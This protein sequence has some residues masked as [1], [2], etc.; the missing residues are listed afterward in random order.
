ML[1]DLKKQS[2]VLCRIFENT[3]DLKREQDYQRSSCRR[4]IFFED[5][6]SSDDGT[7]WHLTSLD[8]NIFDESVENQ[9]MAAIEAI[10]H[11]KNEREQYPGWYIA[12][13]EV[14]R[15][16]Q[17]KTM[18]YSC[19]I[20]IDFLQLDEQLDLCYEFVWRCE[21]GMLAYHG[22]LQKGIYEI[23]RAYLN[24]LKNEGEGVIEREGERV[25]NWFYIGLVLLREYREEGRESEW[26]DILQELTRY[27]DVDSFAKAG[28]E[29]EKIK[30][31]FSKFQMGKVRRL[32]ERCQ[33]PEKAYEL[34]IQMIGLEAECGRA[35]DALKRTKE[36]LEKL[37]QEQE[38]CSESD[39]YYHSIFVALLHMESLL[40]QGIAFKKGEYEKNQESINDILNQAEA[41][42]RFFDWEGILVYVER[43][44]TKW[45]V[46]KNKSR[47]PFELAKETVSISASEN[48]CIESYYLYRV[49]DRMAVPLVSNSVNMVGWLENL[50]FMALQEYDPY[51]ALHMM[52]RGSNGDTAKAC[53][54]RRQMIKFDREMLAGQLEYVRHVV[55]EN[56]EEL[57]EVE[58]MGGGGVW[59][60]LLENLPEIIIRLV[61]RCPD[62]MQCDYLILIKKI[63][64][65]PGL[66]FHQ[67]INK[68]V[69]DML[70]QISEINKM[71]KL[72]EM[73]ITKIV[74]HPVFTGQIKSLDIFEYYFRKENLHRFT[75]LCN[76]KPETIEFLL[77]DQNDTQYVWRT[78]VVRLLTIDQIGMLIPEQRQRMTKKIWS[79]LKNGLP[80]LPGWRLWNYMELEY[81]SGQLP[82]ISIKNYFQIHNMMYL[83]GSEHG[84][85]ITMGRISYLDE[86]IAAAQ[87]LDPDFWNIDEIKL[88][89]QDAIEY[90]Q[91]LKNNLKE[92]APDVFHE[93]R[94]RANKM[95]YMLAE[96][97]KSSSQKFQ[98][99]FQDK[100]QIMLNE[101]DELMI[102][103]KA[104][105]VLFVPE[106][107]KHSF[108]MEIIDAFYSYD[109][110]TTVDALNSAYTLLDKYPDGDCADWLFDEI[111]CILRSRKQPGL[112]TAIVVLHNLLYKKNS[113]FSKSRIEIVDRLLISLEK[114]TQYDKHMQSEK[115]I[116]ETALIRSVCV[117]LA[118][119]I[120]LQE[121][122]GASPG[123]MHWKNVCNGDEFN[124]IRNEMIV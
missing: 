20:R 83:F 46:K 73:L 14:H 61:S 124:D 90:W 85:R 51:L 17:Y 122:C 16:I 68:L 94:K 86:L 57:A 65:V 10:G 53:Y 116:K 123:V 26:E 2:D 32:C 113:V 39:V 60:Q 12:P 92:D 34:Q 37:R 82:T 80:D 35:E 50:W 119:Q 1:S 31:A 38:C 21:T 107:N 13:Y 23:W 104:L 33:I 58:T 120:S 64:E 96:V 41:G 49:V 71:K 81:G 27:Y 101:A 43:E 5:G 48:V 11:W 100:V 95:F 19:W 74:E 70:Q 72:G 102:D 24:K 55:L 62:E 54:S 118:Y 75:S 63:M 40:L 67:K 29:L 115:I 7:D 22:Y 30:F 9:K 103:T 45:Y 84:C 87:E 52:L 18:Q 93:Y 77:S 15:R 6:V 111:V 110:H 76:I 91:I 117:S 79:R 42:K 28:L 105:R 25:R 78:K 97:Y 44:L 4:I 112:I 3:Q 47:Q 121:G 114:S 98:E 66:V 56:L 8:I 108:V 99:D 88:I 106:Y 59:C 36:I 89:Y 69:H 109:E